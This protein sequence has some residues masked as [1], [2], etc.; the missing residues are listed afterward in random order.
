MQPD[1]ARGAEIGIPLAV[2]PMRSKN[3]HSGADHCAADLTGRRRLP[4]ARAAAADWRAS[5]RILVPTSAAGRLAKVEAL[6]LIGV[7][8][9]EEVD[10]LRSLH[11][12]D[13]HAHVHLAAE[14]DDRLHHGLDVVP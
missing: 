2:F 3:A 9:V 5:W 13:G 7:R 8:I 1:Q 4:P 6:H 11:T 14:R 12:L 10:L